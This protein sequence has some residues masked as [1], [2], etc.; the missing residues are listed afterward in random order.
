MPFV[1]YLINKATTLLYEVEFVFHKLIRNVH[2]V[3]WEIFNG[4]NISWVLATYDN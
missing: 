2:T 1:C 3:V 4:K